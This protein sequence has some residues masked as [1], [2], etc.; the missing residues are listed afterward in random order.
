[1]TNEVKIVITSHDHTASGVA[2]SKVSG[3]AAG[4]A[5][6]EAYKSEVIKG[7]RG[8]GAQVSKQVSESMIAG[9][10]GTGE[11]V[12]R[13]LTAGLIAGTKD[14]GQRVAD[15]LN[16][17]LTA[18]VEGTGDKVGKQFGNEFNKATQGIGRVVGKEI[19]LGIKLTVI[20]GTRGVGV[21]AAQKVKSEF[22]MGMARG[23]AINAAA[24]RNG[25]QAADALASGFKSVLDF[26]AGIVSDLKAAAPVAVMAVKGLALATA[27]GAGA[28]GIG[29]GAGIAGG[30]M[31]GLTTGGFIGLG[32][33]LL[34]DNEE[35][36][37]VWTDTFKHIGQDAKE[38]ADILADEFVAGADITAAAWEDKLGPAL[39][40][41][42]TNAQPYVDDFIAMPTN[43]LGELAPGIEKAVANAGPAV[44]GLDLMGKA[45]FK[46]LGDGLGDLSEHSESTKT[47]MIL[48]GEAIGGSIKGLLGFVG[49]LS[50]MVNRNQDEFRVWGQ[51]IGDAADWGG[52]KLVALGDAFAALSH[53]VGSSEFK[54]AVKKLVEGEAYQPPEQRQKDARYDKTKSRYEQA[55]G[56]VASAQAAG[57]GES[58]DQILKGLGLFTTP[59]LID[60]NTDRIRSLGISVD[61]YNKYLAAGIPVSEAQA[62]VQALMEEKQIALVQSTALMSMTQGGQ[63]EA[64]RLQ[65][66]A[67][68]EVASSGMA[69]ESSLMK[70]VSGLTET[71]IAASGATVRFDDLGNAVISVPG[72]KDVVVSAETQQANGNIREVIGS[73]AAVQGKTVYINVVTTGIAS[74]ASAVAAAAANAAAAVPRRNKGGL[75]PGS[76]P[77]VD[78]TLIAATPKE[79]VVN[80]K[81]TAKHLPLLMAINKD[82]G[83]DAVMRLAQDGAGGGGGGPTTGG[84][85]A[86]GVGGATSVEVVVRLDSTGSG[87]NQLFAE[88]AAEAF[89]KSGIK[90]LG[91]TA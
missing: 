86:G 1:M 33:F 73:I 40:R 38:R 18:K 15:K 28:A 64:T 26:G 75:V 41:I 66:G 36:K 39:G 55:Q 83:G 62:N 19:G 52:K 91:L 59:E 71:Q 85:N 34:K 17:V 43:W 23:D 87:W 29:L 56:M 42:F 3:I 32:G 35:V 27:A 84:G 78:S 70:V 16:E 7:T 5:Y 9:S 82:A 81:A 80:R 65:I 53:G 69:V 77:D 25:M 4:R 89:R 20:N 79:F 46:G 63:V 8:V 37:R 72:Q 67:F 60:A 50:D 57:T 31:I 51:K 76:G 45:I 90:V 10:R 88:M 22:E 24:K 44:S 54:E 47:A 6:A 14:T 11:K 74:A 30:L 2:S 13:H 68:A 61:T 21:E 49:D 12:S 58:E 48:G